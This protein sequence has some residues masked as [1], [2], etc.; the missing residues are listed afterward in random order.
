MKTKSTIAVRIIFGLI[1][2][3][4]GLNGFLNFIPMP[5]PSAEGGA[6]LGALFKTGFI[7]PVIK[8]IE[9]LVGLALLANVLV[10]FAL[11]VITPIMV[12][13]NL[14]HIILDPAGAALPV[15]LALLQAYLVYRYFGHYKQLLTIKAEL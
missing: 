12:V 3:I 10:P 1:F 11:V 15:T 14:H 13:M 9:I 2:L 8:A 4:F 7:F 5:A 6:F